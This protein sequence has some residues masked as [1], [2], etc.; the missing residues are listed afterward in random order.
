MFYRRGF[1]T[2][3]GDQ[4]QA[5]C[6]ARTVVP[7]QDH[8]LAHTR[9]GGQRA[10]DFTQLNA[11]AANLD[12]IVIATEKLQGAIRQP[13]TQISG[14][15]HAPRGLAERAHRETLGTQLRLVEIAARNADACDMQLTDHADWYRLAVGIQHIDAGVG[16]RLSN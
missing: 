5:F 11:Q 15:V 12:L 14:S 16:Q 13:A 1:A 3:V 9:A 4:T 6:L 2:Q 8:S 7:G 10:L